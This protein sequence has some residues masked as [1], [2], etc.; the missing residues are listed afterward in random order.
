MCFQG[1]VTCTMK[2]DVCMNVY[3]IEEAKTHGKMKF[4]K[5]CQYQGQTLHN[6]GLMS[7]TFRC[8]CLAK[9]PE[10]CS[11]YSVI[12]SDSRADLTNSYQPVSICEIKTLIIS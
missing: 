7:N 4:G 12:L 8:S 3:Q 11:Y 1:N 9:P 6:T 2:K 10:N 5:A